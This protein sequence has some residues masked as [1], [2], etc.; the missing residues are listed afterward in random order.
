[1]FSCTSL[2][3]KIGGGIGTALAGWMLAASG[4]IPNAVTQVDSCINMLYF[5]Y[6]WIPMIINLVIAFLLSRLKVE[7][8]NARLESAE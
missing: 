5:M 1:M 7:Q 2:G 6:L 4:Y 8:A 3:V